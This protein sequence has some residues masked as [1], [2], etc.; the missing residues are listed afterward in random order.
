MKD[1]VYAKQVGLVRKILSGDIQSV[2]NELS[3]QMTI[4][5]NSEDYEKSR[6]NSR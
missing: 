5:A 6:P 4:A 2:V 3:A 1:E